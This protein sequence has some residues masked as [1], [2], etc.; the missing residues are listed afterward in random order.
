MTGKKSEGGPTACA[1]LLCF[2]VNIP[3]TMISSLPILIP[4]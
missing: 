2:L 4:Q 3:M 1:G